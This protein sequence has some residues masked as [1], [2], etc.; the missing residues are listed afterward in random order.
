M[1]GFDKKLL[2]LSDTH[3]I[4]HK[5]EGHSYSGRKIMIYYFLK[6]KLWIYQRGSVTQKAQA[7]LI[8]ITQCIP[9]S[10]SV[11]SWLTSDYSLYFKGK[12][13]IRWRCQIYASPHFKWCSV[14]P[15]KE[16][17]SPNSLGSKTRANRWRETDR[18]KSTRKQTILATVIG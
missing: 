1:L 17:P 12:R 3:F 6:R 5:K 15:D 16:S 4:V 10:S 18:W 8:L 11:I 2:Y 9:V 7:H 14:V 13:R